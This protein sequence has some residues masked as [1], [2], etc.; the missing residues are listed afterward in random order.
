[1]VT[2]SLKDFWRVDSNTKDTEMI[3]TALFIGLVGRRRSS[4]LCGLESD[5]M[6][7]MGVQQ[8]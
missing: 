1:M 6:T 8:V 5:E 3:H 4:R 2:M 7:S